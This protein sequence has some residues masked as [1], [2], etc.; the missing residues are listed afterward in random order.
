MSSFWDPQSTAAYWL[1]DL[2]LFRF[3]QNEHFSGPPI[4]SCLLANRFKTG[5]FLVKTALFG[6][7]DQN[8]SKHM[9]E[10]S[11]DTLAENDQNLSQT[12]TD[13]RQ[14]SFKKTQPT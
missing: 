6:S 12:T 7:F 4:H 14:T 8:V 3:G 9:T 1:I 13:N 2:K 11:A 5:Q 10:A